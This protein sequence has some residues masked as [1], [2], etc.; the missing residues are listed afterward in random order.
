M[1]I[2]DKDLNLGIN[3][4]TNDFEESTHENNGQRFEYG[5]KGVDRGQ[6][7]C[8]HMETKDKN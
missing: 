4:L 2:V 1:K 7:L 6:S 3:V 5:N 8:R